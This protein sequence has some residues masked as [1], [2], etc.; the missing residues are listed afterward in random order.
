MLLFQPVTKRVESFLLIL[1]GLVDI[2]VVGHAII[3]FTSELTQTEPA[4]VHQLDTPFGSNVFFEFD[5]NHAEGIVFVN[6]DAL[7]WTAH[8]F[9]LI[10]EIL[11]EFLEIQLDLLG[12]VKIK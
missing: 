1:K 4:T 6:F 8:H 12:F 5:L 2:I 3:I 7:H 9:T 10:T 11:F